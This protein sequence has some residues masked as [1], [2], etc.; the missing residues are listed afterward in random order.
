[1][2]ECRPDPGLPRELYGARFASKKP[3]GT[4][5]RRHA[6]PDQFHLSGATGCIG[7]AARGV[8]GHNRGHLRK[9]GRSAFEPHRRPGGR[10]RR[11]RGQ[12]CRKS[13]AAWASQSDRFGHLQ[14]TAETMVSAN[15]E[16]RR[17]VAVGAVRDLR[18]RQRNHPVARVPWTTA[19]QHIAELIEAVDRIER[20]L[21]VVGTRARRMS[22]RSPVRSRRSPSRPICWR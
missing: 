10:T 16:H 14:K 7:R 9:S 2:R 6:C 3:A 18:R 22:P 11:R 19:V 21:G 12:S 5:R 1:M 20:R 13:P 4:G 15:H 17:R 8:V